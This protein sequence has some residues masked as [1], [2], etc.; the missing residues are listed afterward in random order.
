MWN[1]LKDLIDNDT[2]VILGLIGFFV[3]SMYCKQ[4]ELGA[5]IAGGLLMHL[6]NKVNGRLQSTSFDNKTKEN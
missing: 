2:L 6:K 3:I 1:F 5:T 4:P